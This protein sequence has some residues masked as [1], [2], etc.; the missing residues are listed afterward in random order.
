MTQKLFFTADTHFC[1]RFVAEHRGFNSSDEMNEVLIDNWNAVISK[2]DRVYHL[3]DVS[4]GPPTKTRELIDQLNGQIYLISG[5]HD[6]AAE[7]KLCRDRFVW[8]KDYYGL[9]VEDQYICLF[10]Y[11]MRTWNRMH[12][13]SYHLHGHSHGTLEEPSNRSFD[14][15]V[16]CW[17]FKPVSYEQ[18]CEKMATKTFEPVDHHGRE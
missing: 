11:A 15:G 12:H 18:V 17:N 3:G 5:N 4:L 7:H 1:H 6:T 8:I 16:D 9:K 2:S 13:N 14:I 10:H